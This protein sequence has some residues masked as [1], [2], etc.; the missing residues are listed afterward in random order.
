[1]R[2]TDGYLTVAKNGFGEYEEKHSRFL[3]AV[4]PC[5][6]E[7]EANE[8]LAQ[9]RKKYFDARHNVYA[10]VLKDKTAR[11][12]DDGEPHGTAGKPILDIILGNSL[13][14]VMVIVTRY[15]GGTLLGTGGLVRAYTQS[16]K[17][18]LD[19]ATLCEMIPCVTAKTVCTYSD[20]NTL[21]PM[22]LKYECE[23]TDTVFENDTTVYYKIKSDSAVRF[24]A[25]LSEK[26]AGKLKFEQI[27]GGFLKK[28]LKK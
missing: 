26:F 17:A 18:A 3:A 16:T 20:Y 6:S 19:N 12:S 4:L 2:K 10:Y 28:I 14:D 25:S 1:M 8:L 27:S 23:I 5:Q 13:C 7:N 9:Y 24:E 15:F 22:L 21:M 11:F